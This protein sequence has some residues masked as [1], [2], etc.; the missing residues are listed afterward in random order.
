M[1]QAVDFHRDG[2]EVGF[3]VQCGGRGPARAVG[4]YGNGPHQGPDNGEP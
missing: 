1:P 4:V 3:V 2:R